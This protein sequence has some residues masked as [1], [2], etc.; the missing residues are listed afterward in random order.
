MRHPDVRSL[1]ASLVRDDRE[2]L[3]SYRRASIGFSSEAF[4][5]G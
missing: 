1:L 2:W 5:A 3:Y 4:Q